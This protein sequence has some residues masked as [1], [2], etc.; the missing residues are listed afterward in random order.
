MRRC[1]FPSV[2]A[3]VA[4]L[5]ASAC[6]QD[7]DQFNPLPSPGSSGSSGGGGQTAATSGSGAGGAE[8]CTNG[9]DDDRDGAVDCADDDCAGFACVAVPEGWEG[10]GIL[11]A[12]P[13]AADVDCPAGFPMRVDVGGRGPLDEPATCSPCEC[14]APTVACEAPRATV[15]RGE[16]CDGSS[17]T[18]SVPVDGCFV[19]E[20]IDPGSYRAQAPDVDTARCEASGGEATL[21]PPRF[22]TEGL[23]CAPRADTGGCAAGEACAPRDI[24]APFEPGV[25]IWREGERRCPDGFDERH[26]FASSVDDDRGCTRC[27]CDADGVGCAATL[28]F[29]QRDGCERPIATASFDGACA[30]DI[31]AAASLSLEVTPTGDCQPRGGAPTGEIEEGDDKITVCCAR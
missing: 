22:A 29:F 3:L 7:F 27:T 9:D 21:P 5:A 16:A 6:T 28:T 30:E 26:E 18:L 4:L 1:A 8:Q 17:A 20:G 10:P 2:T 24:D 31:P 11:Y 13:D 15:Y 25:C 12:G 14:G 19:V 23:V